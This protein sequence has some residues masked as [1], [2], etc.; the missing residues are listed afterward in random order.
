M[1]FQ[2]PLLE[3]TEACYG[4]LSEA[5]PQTV[6]V[7][8]LTRSHTVHGVASNWFTEHVHMHE[9]TNLTNTNGK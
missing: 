3:N 8:F 9:V 7:S 2:L 6:S 4:F 1:C 5:W